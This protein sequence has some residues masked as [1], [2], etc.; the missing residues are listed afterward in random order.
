MTLDEF[1]NFRFSKFTVAMVTNPD[2][3]AVGYEGKV[4]AVNFSEGLIEIQDIDGEGIWKRFENVKLRGGV[5]P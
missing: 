4:T 3:I 1:S 2:D 5:Q